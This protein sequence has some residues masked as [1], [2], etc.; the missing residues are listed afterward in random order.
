M[1][2]GEREKGYGLS[3]KKRNPTCGRKISS[4]SLIQLSTHAVVDNI[5]QL[6]GCIPALPRN[7][8]ARILYLM[9]KRSNLLNDDTLNVVCSD[10]V[11]ELDFTNTAMISDRGLMELPNLSNLYKIDLNDTR[12]GTRDS[13]T[14]LA[15]RHIASCCPNLRIAYFRRC[16]N[17]SDE[18]VEALA[19]E[20]NRLIELNLSGCTNITDTSTRAISKFC[21]HLQSLNLAYTSITDESAYNLAQGVCSEN[22]K[23]VHISHCAYVTDDGVEALLHG[24]KNVSYLEIQGCPLLTHDSIDALGRQRESFNFKQFNFTIPF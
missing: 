17:I 3:A 12:T 15:L 13:V 21:S 16:I 19:K 4:K 18:G 14:S 5:H 24:T 8:K 6:L 10:A 9:S 20:C 7:L 11:H 23:E 2:V 1:V 22:L